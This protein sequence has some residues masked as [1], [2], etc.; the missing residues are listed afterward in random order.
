M[1]GNTLQQFIDDL[2][3]MGG[4]EKEYLYRGKRYMLEC[5]KEPEE[6]KIVFIIFQCFGNQEI[7]FQC[8]G[9]TFRE[10]FEQYE[11]APIYDGKTIYDAEREIEILYG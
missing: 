11:Q 5:E 4:S 3:T 8:K 6:G 2:L 9:K 1:K 7:I 10:C